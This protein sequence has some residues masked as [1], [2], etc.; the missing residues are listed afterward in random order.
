[1]PS[2]IT[3]DGR[4]FI[5]AEQAAGRGTRQIRRQAVHPWSTRSGPGAA[6]PAGWAAAIDGSAAGRQASQI[7][8]VSG[9]PERRCGRCGTRGLRIRLRGQP[10][11]QRFVGDV[12]NALAGHGRLDLGGLQNLRMKIKG[13]GAALHGFH[14][15][16]IT[17]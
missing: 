12:R 8:T 5:A 4:S 13:R 14:D 2:V 16:I 1:M 10:P 15:V 11:R 7:I 6:A 3:D 9:S 17:L